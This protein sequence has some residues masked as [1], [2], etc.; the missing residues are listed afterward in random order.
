MLHTPL[1]PFQKDGVRR[2]TEFGGRALLGDD[3]G[4]GK[5]LQTLYWAWRML[6]ADPPGPVVAVVPA[7]LKVNWAREAERHLGQYVEVLDH[8]TVPP[9][10][11]P[12]AD[13]NRIYAIS[14]DILV[15][16]KWSTR[17]KLPPDSWAGWLHALRPRLVVADEGHYCK[18]HDSKRTRALRK[19]IR[20]VPHVLIL[21]G[22]PV[23]N[24]PMD[25][26]PLL[27]MIRPDLF[28]SRFEFGVVYTNAVRR[29]WGWE[30]PGCRNLDQLNDLLLN[31]CLIRRRKID[32]AKDLPPIVR[33]VVEIPIAVRE[34]R[35]AEDD[36]LGWLGGFDGPAA[37]RAATAAGLQ[38]TGHLRRLA[39][40]LKVPGVIAWVDDFLASGNKLLLG[41]T[42]K[43]VTY[44]IVDHF[45]QRCV[46]VDGDLT[47]PEKVARTDLFNDPAAGVDL[48]VGN[49]QS[50]GVGW[51]C[52][53]TSDAAVCEIPWTSAELEQFWGRIYGLNRGLA[54]VPATVRVLL[55]ADTIE[56]DICKTLVRKQ[57]YSDAA[58]DG[59]QA[60][61]D[62]DT[63]SAVVEQMKHRRGK[64]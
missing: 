62:F 7:H 63:F 22:T 28:P 34:Y 9:G 8:Q 31:T 18:A 47:G 11:P 15:P 33:S 53:A 51:N 41:A 32:V 14:Y 46:L 58:I 23:T 1:Y 13:P 52:T 21:T 24:S 27:N 43:K 60:A 26:W 57:G 10:K 38:R 19:M 61:D 29:P 36:F 48:C 20:G 12:P 5:T 37:L 55:A 17:C 30:Y 59:G 35:K 25:L 50:A 45:D 6:P 56:A 39:G 44:P 3:V 2:I 64:R 49:T 4:L 42:H 16:P 40:V 54:G